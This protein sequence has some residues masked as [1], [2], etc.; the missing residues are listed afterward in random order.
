MESVEVR[1]ALVVARSG[2]VALVLDLPLGVREAEAITADLRGT[3]IPSL[4]VE[5]VVD[6][7]LRL[8]VVGSGHVKFADSETILRL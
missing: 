8:V 5:V 6:L 7:V 4:R 1:E 2:A 3:S